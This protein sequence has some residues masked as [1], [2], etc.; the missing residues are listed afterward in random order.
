MNGKIK[1]ISGDKKIFE[2]QTELSSMNIVDIAETLEEK[3]KQEMAILF[4]LLTKDVAGG[5][6][7]YLS[8]NAQFL[9][10]SL[11]IKKPQRF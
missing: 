9:I 1:L 6:F 5:V 8:L 4:R 2:I 11:V 3:N 10:G 7:S